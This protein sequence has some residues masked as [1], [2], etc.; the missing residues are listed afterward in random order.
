MLIEFVTC[1][2]ML[3]ILPLVSLLRIAMYNHVSSLY[4][5]NTGQLSKYVCYLGK[6]AI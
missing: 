1:N 6:P 5:S 4:S 2:N 3:V